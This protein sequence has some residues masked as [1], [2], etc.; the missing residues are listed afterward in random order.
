MENSDELLII[1]DGFLGDSRSFLGDPAGVFIVENC[2]ELLITL[3]EACPVDCFSPGFSVAVSDFVAFTAFESFVA[4]G[5]GIVSCTL[6]ENLSGEA[7]ATG[8]L[9]DTGAATAAGGDL[10]SCAP[11]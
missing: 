1:S 2:D 6:A 3:D 10:F 4:C 8:F 5:P 7:I 9:V 11:A